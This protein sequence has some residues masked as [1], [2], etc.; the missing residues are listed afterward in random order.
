MD[1]HHQTDSQSFGWGGFGYSMNRTVT[2][3]GRFAYL[4]NDSPSAA[5]NDED[6]VC[7]NLDTRSAAWSIN[8]DFTGTPA[9]NNGILYVLSANTVQA[10][11]TSDGRLL[12]S[13]MAPVGEFLT[14]QPIIT[15]DLVIAG[16]GQKTYLFGRY[17]YALV[18]TLNRGG[19]ASVG[20]DQVIIAGTDGTVAAYAAQP[21]VTFSPSGG[22]FE[23]PV[24]V[25]LSA[26]EPEGRIYYTVDGSAP[27][28]SSASVTSGQTVR[29]N[30]TGK[31]RAILVKGSAVSRINEAS[32]TMLD[33]D[34]DGLPDWWEK[35]RFGGISVTSSDRDSDGDGVSDGLE[36]IAGT[37]PLDATDFFACG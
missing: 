11:S 15:D 36:F 3:Q 12:G 19:S 14:G 30:W 37:D 2:L 22:A 28:F 18:Q 32:Y 20:D 25:I 34:L 27:D 1:E 35:S 21:A 10:R 6:L 8:G 33:S 13:F 29:V 23:N 17:D 7:V 4:V 9:V 31:I 16:S 24:Y 5:Y 26:A